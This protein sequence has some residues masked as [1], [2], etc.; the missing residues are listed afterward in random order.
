MKS[1]KIDDTF[2]YSSIFFFREV[3]QV[4][5]RNTSKTYVDRQSKHRA[6]LLI[7]KFQRTQTAMNHQLTHEVIFPAKTRDFFA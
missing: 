4:S 3:S 1:S 7:S 6:I 5:G 2:C